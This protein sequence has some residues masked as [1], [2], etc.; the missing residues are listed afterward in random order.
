MHQIN[1]FSDFFD[2]FAGYRRGPERRQGAELHR[3]AHTYMVLVFM[4]VV[5]VA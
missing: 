3:V 4:E 2:V 1:Q 5:K